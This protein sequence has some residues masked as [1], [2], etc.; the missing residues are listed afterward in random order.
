MRVGALCSERREQWMA[1]SG[2]N[3]F[4][5]SAP[6]PRRAAASDLIRLL[7]LLKMQI[8]GEHFR[9]PWTTPYLWKDRAP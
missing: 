7:A 2:H 1:S 6:G 8:L 9:R 3:P 5:E 4:S